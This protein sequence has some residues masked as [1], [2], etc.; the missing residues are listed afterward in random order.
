[1]NAV[2]TY[3]TERTVEAKLKLNNDLMDRDEIHRKDVTRTVSEKIMTRN[4]TSETEQKTGAAETKGVVR[5]V[6]K[7][8]YVGRT[9]TETVFAEVNPKDRYPIFVIVHVIKSGMERNLVSLKLSKNE[10]NNL[11]CKTKCNIDAYE[12]M[13]SRYHVEAMHL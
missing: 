7:I 11:F 5:S 1:M 13:T 4:G 10:E 3:C 9:S 8:T 2:R 12:T 6:R